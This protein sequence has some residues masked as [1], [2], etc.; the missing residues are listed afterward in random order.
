ML[1]EYVAQLSEMRIHERSTLYVN[2]AHV[3]AEDGELRMAIEEEY[4]RHVQ[5]Y[6]C[7]IIAVK[8]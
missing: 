3:E 4:Y 6:G 8:V 2:M 7:K 1:Q 5:S